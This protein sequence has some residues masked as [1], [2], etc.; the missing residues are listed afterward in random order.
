MPLILLTALTS[1]VTAQTSNNGKITVPVLNQQNVA[2][3]NVTVELR[4]SKDSV[5]VKTAI[6]DKAG[7]A[8]FEKLKPGSYVIK[9]SM[10]N[11]APQY[12][13]VINLSGEQNDIKAPAIL[14]QQRSG[15]LKEV[16]VST[17][18]PFIQ[19]LTDRIVVNVENSIVSAGA[20]A[21]D[22]LK[23]D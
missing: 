21:M 7:I 19:K 16:T 15:E 9:A 17:R 4:R 10:V 23:R 18:K 20:S 22:V 8:L 2:L 5:L 1:S 13:S 6:T 14:L 12:S 3:E 11:Y